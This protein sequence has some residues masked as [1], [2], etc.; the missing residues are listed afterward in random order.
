MKLPLC[1]LIVSLLT[2]NTVSGAPVQ[3]WFESG[4]TFY[5]QNNYDSAL[6]YYEKISEAGINNSDVFYNIGNCY[7]RLNKVG[8]ARL[9]FEKANKI[10][11]NDPDITTN[12]RFVTSTLVDK[13]PE[14]QQGFVSSVLWRIHTLFSISAQLWILLALSVLLAI[15]VSA[16]LHIK[17]KYRLWAIYIS[18][19]VSLFTI[20]LS[21]SLGFKIYQSE[22]IHYAIVL[23]SVTDAKNQPNGGNILFSIHEGTKV[24]IRKTIDNWSLISLPNGYSGWV[25]GSDIGKI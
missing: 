11:P 4:N 21:G 5:A 7:F 22:R 23:D 15:S 16:S 9:Y 17:G 14:P 25:A 3:H 6:V 2:I 10:K 18:V 19:I 20:T 24:R 8:L 13:I 12:I 1:I